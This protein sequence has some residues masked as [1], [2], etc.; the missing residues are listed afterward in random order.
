[1]ADVQGEGAAASPAP[2]REDAVPTTAMGD[3]P[4]IGSA[5]LQTVEGSSIAPPSSAGV[6]VHQEVH[7]EPGIHGETPQPTLHSTEAPPMAAGLQMKNQVRRF[8]KNNPANLEVFRREGGQIEA[9]EKTKPDSES[10][11]A[12]TPPKKS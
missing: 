10:G 1:M 11:A 9:F 12:V 4:A 7:S 3:S 8:S 2:A 6:T 5:P